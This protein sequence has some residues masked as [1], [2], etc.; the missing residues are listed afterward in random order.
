MVEKE[1]TSAITVKKHL[2]LL[3]TEIH[4]KLF[5]PEKEQLIVIF[6]IKHLHK[7]IITSY[8]CLKHI[9]LM[10]KLILIFRTMNELHKTVSKILEIVTTLDVNLK[11]NDHEIN[12]KNFI[13][14]FPD[15]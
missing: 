8:I 9:K 10:Y 12:D 4:M 15:Y 13:M 2:N 6:V 14:I 1:V 5:T 7:N 3:E 11:L